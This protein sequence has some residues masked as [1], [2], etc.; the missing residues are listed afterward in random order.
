MTTK[1][2]VSMGL[3]ISLCLGTV[4][5]AQPA[6]RRP[7]PPAPAPA[8]APAPT[9]T[10]TPAPTPA[11]VPDARPGDPPIVPTPKTDEKAG[12]NESLQNGGDERPWARGVSSQDQKIA[13][14]LF[15]DGNVQLN[16]GLFIKAAEKY[17]EALKHWQHPAIYYNLALALINLDQPI[18]VYLSLQK[19]MAYGTAPLEKEKFE[20]AKEYLLLVQQQLADIEVSCDKKGAKVSVDGKEAF[21]VGK[22]D[23]SGQVTNRFAQKVKIGKHQ[24]VAEKEGYQA[25]IKAPYIGPGEHFRIELKLYTAEDLTRYH[26]KFDKTWIPYAVMG[27]GVVI[28]GV[29]G[30]L[31]LS[32]KSSYDDFDKRVETCSM[33]NSGCTVSGDLKSIK[34]S[35][36]TKKTLSYVAFGIGAGTI[37]TGAILA[38]VNRRRAYQVRPEELTGEQLTIAPIVAPG[39][40]GIG[41][42]GHF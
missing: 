37:I 5:N 41:A 33:M 30:L 27:A 9:P 20:H 18:E 15:H 31:Q 17:R 38:V 26:R 28:A 7:A 10:P 22:P 4:A 19:A 35:G 8:P 11:P 21:T 34:D 3:S 16:D 42:V 1:R 14:N 36:D 6:R 25:R 23:A 29:G 32:A 2:L 40:T 12:S 24:F 39:L 13:L